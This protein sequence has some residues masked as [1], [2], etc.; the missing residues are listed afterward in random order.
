MGTLLDQS[1]KIES[2]KLE[3]RTFNNQKLKVEGQSMSHKVQ[4]NMETTFNEFVWLVADG[5]C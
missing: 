4:P 3:R 5:W 2:K 1:D